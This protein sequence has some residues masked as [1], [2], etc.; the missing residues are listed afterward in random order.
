[1]TGSIYWKGYGIKCY[2]LNKTVLVA[3][4]SLYFQKKSFFKLTCILPWSTLDSYRD[5]LLFRE[6]ARCASGES[7]EI[8]S[9]CRF[10]TDL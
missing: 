8:T 1:M 7:Y 3:L 9:Y 2:L 10:D 5:A 4:I 6:L